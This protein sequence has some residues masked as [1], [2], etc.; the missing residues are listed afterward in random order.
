M[1]MRNDQERDQ[2]I[3]MLI[4][5]VQELESEVLR[6]KRAHDVNAS[7]DSAPKETI[8]PAK[9]AA[10]SQP[11]LRKNAKPFSSATLENIIGTRWIGAIGIVA[12]ILGVG[13][14]LKYSFDNNLIGEA[15]RVMLGIVGGIAFL[16]TG[17]YL[18]QKKNLGRYAQILSGGGLAVLYLS[19]YAA[20]ALFHLIPALLAAVGMI[21][22]TTTG[23]T[24]SHR[25]AA[26]SL[27]MVALS[28]GLLTPVVLSTGENQ[29][30]VLFS[31]ILLL[32]SGTLLLL[33]FRQWP[34]LA[35][36]SL[37]G[38][39]LLYSSWHQAYYSADQQAMAFIA[40][41]VYFALYNLYLL[42][43]RVRK[44]SPSTADHLVIFGSGLFFFLAFLA[45]QEFADGWP[46]R[47]FALLLASIE[48]VLASFVSRGS[49]LARMSVVSYAALSVVMTVIATFISFEQGW[50]LPAISIEMAI[51]G[52][53]ACKLDLPDFRWG[54]YLLG[55]FVLMR[56]SYDAV[57][58]LDPFE[59]FVPVFNRRFPGCAVS[60]ASFY[61][62]LHAGSR[63]RNILS[64][65]ERSVQA[66]IFFITQALSLILLS[67]EIHDFFN[68][69]GVGSDSAVYAY[70]MSLSVLWALYASFLTGVGIVKRI[71]RARILGIV[72]LGGAVLK[73]FFMD[74]SFLEPLY[75]IISFIVLGLLLLAVSYGYNRFRHIIF[76]E[77]QP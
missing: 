17:E 21:A 30:L 58:S 5:R 4:A 45:Q 6:L 38:T 54:V 10:A 75:R 26:Y 13:F 60:V 48:I 8:V 34:S 29:S 55:I 61:V 27:A 51:L 52:W 69:D 70:Q 76:G 15:G 63:Y 36:V 47:F 44:A 42:F 7:A 67:L 35:A 24:L 59:R 43:F 65:N 64:H 49:A 73:V 1:G 50:V 53:W 20:F 56:F 77:D 22:V 74:L 66:I 23:M 18:Q 57:L 32:D 9:V 2:C 72:I 39:A 37:F 14:F 16:A 19:F 40:V 68:I 25:Y 28:G 33:R 71:R 31:Y 62:L 41:T 11:Q 3:D 46:V 12:V